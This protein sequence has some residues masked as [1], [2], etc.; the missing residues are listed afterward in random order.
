MYDHFWPQVISFLKNCTVSIST[1]YDWDVK[2]TKFV[3]IKDKKY[4][5]RHKLLTYIIY[6]NMVVMAWNLF[7]VSKKETN[8]TF[9]Q[10]ISVGISAA[11]MFMTVNRW[12]HHKGAHAI[13]EFL[14]C[15]VKFQRSSTE[16]GNVRID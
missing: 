2:G 1:P 4:V 14:N 3:V 13:V 12:M 8:N 9:L 6:G 7:Q 5:K 10:V 16:R 11:T 15:M